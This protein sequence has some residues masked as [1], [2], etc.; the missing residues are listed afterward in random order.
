MD[1][2]KKKKKKK[3]ERK[4]E[5]KEG[6]ERKNEKFLKQKEVGNSRVVKSANEVA[7]CFQC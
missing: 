2:K 4:K 5:R 7:I 6:R 1:E 3:E